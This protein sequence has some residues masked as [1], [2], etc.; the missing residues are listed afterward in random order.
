MSEHPFAGLRVATREVRWPAC[1]ARKV[2]SAAGADR[3]SPDD[4]CRKS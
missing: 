3:R 1:K 4:E 2:L